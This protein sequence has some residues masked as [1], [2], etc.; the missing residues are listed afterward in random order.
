MR[1]AMRA[2]RLGA[3]ALAL[4]VASAALAPVPRG[5][6]QEFGPRGRAQEFEQ[7]RL[8]H[9]DA[10]LLEAWSG[11]GHDDRTEIVEWLG[12]E[13][14][15]TRTLQ[16]DLVRF[17]VDASD[18]DKGL[19]PRAEPPPMYDPVE[20]APG[21]VISRRPLP[22]DG[23]VALRERARLLADVPE[24]RLDPAWSYDWSSGQV[25]SLKEDRDPDRLFRNALRGF[26]PDLDYAEALL[27]RALDDGSQRAVL[28]AFAHA[29]TDRNGRVY[30]G[31]TL[32]DA[33]ASGELIEMPDV[34]TLGIV[35]DVLGD[36]KTWVAPV[37]PSQH[38]ELYG[39]LGELFVEAHRHRGLR[40]ALART[41]RA[42]RCCATATRTR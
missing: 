6:A 39:K 10:E 14:R 27:E 37:P 8:A 38:D 25:V 35:H 42:P 26:P 4:L 3:T 18:V 24:R 22:L 2:H 31:L 40:T 12:A 1:L 21:Q 15:A 17:L 20:H 23:D 32:Y 11:L 13:L 34:D 29:Y 28:A 41:C 5:R 36:E 7:P 16:L 19:W 9:T 30:P 33:W